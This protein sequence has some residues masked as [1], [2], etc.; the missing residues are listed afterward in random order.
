MNTPAR[1]F[2]GLFS[3][4]ALMQSVNAITTVSQN[5]LTIAQNAAGEVVA[6]GSG[7]LYA[8]CYMH[9]FLPP[10]FSIEGAVITVH[11]APAPGS[12]PLSC[13]GTGTPPIT[14]AYAESVDFG[15]LQ[16]GTYAVVW[17]TLQLTGLY[18]VSALAPPFSIGPGITGNWFDPAQ[19]GHGFSIEVLPGNQMLAEWYVFAPDGGQTWLV[20]S[21]PITNDTAV[22]QAYQ[23][24]GAG[25]KFPPHFNPAQVANHA[26]G[27]I[28]FTFADCNTGQASWAPSASGYTAGAMAITRL[29]MPAGISCP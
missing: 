3:L 19:S 15:L 6:S 1:I 2:A 8:S 25:G 16:P 11:D 5:T 17:P 18:T 21:G 9:D 28:T 13:A 12:I 4:C 27:T 20:A 24:S 10:T 29:T 26:W 23:P 14:H 7:V 22:L